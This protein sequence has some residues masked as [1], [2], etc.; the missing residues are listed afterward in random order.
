MGICYL[1]M[2]Q[3]LL[4]SPNPMDQ[5]GQVCLRNTFVYLSR[6]GDPDDQ[7]QTL[8]LLL[9]HE[10]NKNIH[11]PVDENLPINQWLVAVTN[12]IRFSGQ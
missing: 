9:Q 2:N 1:I 3:T 11:S 12:S 4:L 6:K 8:A 10:N 5:N 7:R